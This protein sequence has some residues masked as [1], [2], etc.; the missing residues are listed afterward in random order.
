MSPAWFALA[1]LVLAIVLSIVT[2]VNV[3]VVAV[4]L[5]WVAGVGFAKL[6]PDAV[7]GGFPVTLFV[8]LTG[9]T[10]LFGAAEANGTLAR[11]T[12]KA[13]RL[14]RG[15]ARWLPVAFFTLACA[16]S[17]VGPGAIS[18]VAL[19][20]PLAMPVAR[21]A[22][23][24]AF[25][26]ALAV[27]N[28]AN[29]GNLSPISSVGVIANGKMAEAGLGGHDFKV[30]FANFASHLLVTAVVYVVMRGYRRTD[31]TAAGPETTGEAP[32]TR[33]QW[34]TVVV[35]LSWVVAVV[36]LKY[37]VG[38]TGFAA[39]AL[40][41][42]ARAVDDQ[43]AIRRMPW[44]VILMVT[45]MSLLV[46]VL[47]RTGG[48]DLFTALLAK[49]ASAGSLNGVIALVTGVIST[50]SSTSGVVLPTFLP[51]VPGLV[52]QV[53]GGNPLAVAL[54][55]N[56]G[57]SLVDVSPLS[58]LGALCVAAVANPAEARLLFRRMLV[59]GL[60]MSVVGAVL[61]QLLAGVVARW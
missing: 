8:T 10:L 25:L 38:L 16:V 3:G 31:V 59:W 55:I 11:L 18:S 61:C 54:S 58:T 44:G 9:V 26:M 14:V 46:G 41:V 57:S 45:G 12:T 36:G 32:L 43:D 20:A 19:L 29:A 2:R 33:A 27:A 51:T 39:T 49:L 17:S 13:V 52:A 1:A 50:Y 34:L 42:L 28:G 60:S 53:G 47:E 37:P 7:L 4:A 30:W 22:G 15:D 35:V 21:R 5:A 48:L 23:V 24:P 40:L 56:V 6:K